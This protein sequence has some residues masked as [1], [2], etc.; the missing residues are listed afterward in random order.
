MRLAPTAVF[1]LLLASILIAYL[2]SEPANDKPMLSHDDDKV[3]FIAMGDMPYNALENKLLTAPDGAIAQAIVAYD[4][5]VLIHYGDLKSGG[6]PCTDELLKE[7][8]TQLSNL[9]PHKIVYTPGDNDWTDCDR[10]FIKSPMDELQRL[11]FLRELFYQ[12]QGAQMTRDIAGLVHQHQLLGKGLVENALWQIKDVVFGTLHMVGG[13]N[14][15]KE[16]LLSD[17]D[18]ALDAVEQRDAANLAWIDTL[19]ARADAAAA[20]VISFQADVYHPDQADFPVICTAQRR[21]E[22][23]GFKLI[24]EYIEQQ[25]AQYKRPVLI[26]HGDTSTYC[27][28]QPNAALASNLWRLNGPGDFKYPDAAHVSVDPDHRQNPFSVVTLLGHEAPSGVCE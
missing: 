25:S 4:P 27:L 7:R 18:R 1:A 13:N 6:E 23:D 26:I 10:D 2:P 28:H 16:I 9:N 22:C 14:G 3:W 11:D 24:R 21:E 20:L 12:G 17:K 5:A 8:R 19:F 15:R